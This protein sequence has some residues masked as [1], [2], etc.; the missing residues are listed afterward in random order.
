MARLTEFITENSNNITE[1]QYC[2]TLMVTGNLKYMMAAPNNERKTLCEK[3]ATHYCW[4]IKDIP[5]AHVFLQ[6]IIL[7]FGNLCVFNS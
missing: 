4:N 3:T 6:K 2:P 5:S 1:M 7:I